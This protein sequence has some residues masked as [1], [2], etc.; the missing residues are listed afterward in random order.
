M[1]RKLL[2]FSIIFLF[3]GMSVVSSAG[4]IVENIPTYPK[5]MD[6]VNSL[7]EMPGG[8]KIAYAY[9]TGDGFH[10]ESPYWFYLD[11]PEFD[12]IWWGN[13]P[14]YNFPAGGTWTNDG[15]WLCCEYG[16]GR[17]WEID[18]ITFDIEVI[19]G[20]GT[21]LNGL[22]YNPV[23]EKLYGASS[24]DLYEINITTGEQTYI[25][26]F[27]TV[28]A[29]IAIAF[30]AD[31]ICYGW[32]VK[33]AGDSYLFKIDTGTGEATTVG[34]LGMTLTFAQDGH[35]DIEDDILYLA[36][37][38]GGSQYLL[39]KCDEDTGECTLV[40]KFPAIGEFTAFVIPYG[41]HLPIKPEIT[42]PRHGR[43]GLPNLFTVDNECNAMSYKWDW[44]DGN[45]SW[46]RSD[47][48]S[49]IWDKVG[50]YNVSVMTRN[51]YGV[52]DWS[53]PISIKIEDFDF[54]KALMFGL[55]D[56]FNI[57]ENLTIIEADSLLYLGK[58]VLIK[59]F[60]SGERIIVSE[61]L[62]GRIKS[63]F[64]LGFFKADIVGCYKE[65]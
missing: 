37:Y 52:S 44:G 29:M 11:G 21:S 65:A 61:T 4:D 36:A 3:I 27:G 48:T 32:D 40:G 47:N 62:F 1:I 22:A 18:P 13:S 50:T 28:T 51:V 9:C 43:P 42:G 19:G 63:S 15:R 26:A 25:G 5:N 49:H 14:H 39:L 12:F 45:Y 34:S 58:P 23:N 59:W 20:G 57:T 31:G 24:Y 60:N 41:G 46:N 30:D 10:I 35:F 7:L 6:A 38:T 64:I 54:N 33:F 55:I 16:N 53:D 56:Y 2:A 17:I 8:R